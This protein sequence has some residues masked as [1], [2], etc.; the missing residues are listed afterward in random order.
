MC[1]CIIWW[2]AM[3]WLGAMDMACIPPKLWDMV[4]GRYPFS[5]LGD[6]SS[7]GPR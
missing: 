1:C 4:V 7:N 2:E 3:S 5:E 6:A